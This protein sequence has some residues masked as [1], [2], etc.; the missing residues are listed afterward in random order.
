MSIERRFG[1][2]DQKNSIVNTQFTT[3]QPDELSMNI[4]YLTT[5]STIDG[6][7]LSRYVE[8]P[9]NCSALIS[10]RKAQLLP[11]IPSLG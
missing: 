6:F 8:S 11:L 10:P 4:N 9:F 3:V 1:V 7:L 2:I 5:A